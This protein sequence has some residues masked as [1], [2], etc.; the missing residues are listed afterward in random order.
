MEPFL[1]GITIPEENED[2][3]FLN[4]NE[5]VASTLRQK[6]QDAQQEATLQDLCNAMEDAARNNLQIKPPRCKRRLP[7]RNRNTH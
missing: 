2:N 7:P 3:S 6:Q 5:Q 4:F 1:K